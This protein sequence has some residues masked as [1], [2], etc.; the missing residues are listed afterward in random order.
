VFSARTDDFSFME[1]HLSRGFRWNSSQPVRSCRHWIRRWP[2]FG[3]QP[4]DTGEELHQDSDLSHAGPTSPA[5][6]KRP[7]NN[8]GDQEIKCEKYR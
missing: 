2:Q 1:T 4:Q 5:I 7:E 8:R 6:G 3:D